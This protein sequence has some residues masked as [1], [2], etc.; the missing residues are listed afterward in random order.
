[1][2]LHQNLQLFVSFQI[3]QQIQ[4]NIFFTNCASI[5]IEKWDLIMNK[6]VSNKNK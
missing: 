5:V 6:I 4:N 2:A 1:M 3:F